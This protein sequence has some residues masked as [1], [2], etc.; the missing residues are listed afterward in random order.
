MDAHSSCALFCGCR[1][2]RLR[3]SQ[4]GFYFT[5]PILFS[6]TYG[7]LIIYFGDYIIQIGFPFASQGCLLP[8]SVLVSVVRRLPTLPTT[9]F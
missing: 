2:V 3:S 7:F 4:N 1:E 8:L 9:V 5:F 6:N